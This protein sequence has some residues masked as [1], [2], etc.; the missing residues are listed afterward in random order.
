[1]KKALLY[2]MLLVASSVFA[3]DWQINLGEAKKLAKKES[4]KVI[5]VFQGSDWCA[6]C[7][8]LD[9]KI[10]NTDVFKA[11]QKEHYVMLRVDFPRRKKNQLPEEQKTH[12][13][14]LA[15]NYNRDGIFPLV[16][17]L[18]ENGEILG[19]T[20]YKKLT[21]QAYINHLESF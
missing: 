13:H 20:G 11:Y 17:V 7:I 18:G 16:V 9:K 4:K 3:Q 12:N 19:K 21:P 1:M 2:M 10:W 5:M 6:P 15:M 8:K 14:Q